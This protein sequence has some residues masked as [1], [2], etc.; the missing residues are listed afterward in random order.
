MV[1]FLFY[2][3]MDELLEQ[4]SSNIILALCGNKTDYEEEERQIKSQIAESYA[5]QLGC[6]YI[7]TS[8]KLNINIDKLFEELA[9]KL[10]AKS[11]KSHSGFSL[12]DED[13]SN[14]QS[15]CSRC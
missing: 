7:E 1:I 12:D 10:P 3:R 6:I 9:K 8:A 13:V 15:R 5:A 2:P 11:E 4:A 14:D